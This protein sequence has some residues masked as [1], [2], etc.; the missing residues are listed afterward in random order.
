MKEGINSVPNQLFHYSLWTISLRGIV[1]TYLNTQEL[2]DH[3]YGKNRI[4]AILARGST[5]IS[6]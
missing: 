2:N 1:V 5:D 4:R 3:T 6:T